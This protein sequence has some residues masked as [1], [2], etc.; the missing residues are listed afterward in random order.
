[1]LPSIHVLLAEDN[2]DDV[3]LIRHAFAGVSSVQLNDVVPDGVETLAYLRR[4]GRYRDAQRPNLLL[5]DINMPRKDGFEVLHEL[6]ADPELRALPV[7][8][9]TTSSRD[10]DIVRSYSYGACSYISKPVSLREFK[11]ALQQF[12]R[13]WTMVARVPQH[14]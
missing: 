7:V 1:M 10:V 11:V 13:Y 4:E 2:E 6:K 14:I 9:L 5:L 12:E 8:M 3:F